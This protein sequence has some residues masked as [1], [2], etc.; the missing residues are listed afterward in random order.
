MGE[1]TPLS[2]IQKLILRDFYSS[3]NQ[4]IAVKKSE[5]KEIWDDFVKNRNIK[6]Y[7]HLAEKVPAFF[8]ELNKALTVNKN[9]QPAVFSECVYAQ[10]LAQKFKLPKFTNLLDAKNKGFHNDTVE[11]VN[12]TGLSV[13]YCYSNADDT[14]L[15]FQAGGAGSVDCALISQIEK[16]L[17]MIEFKE[18]YART[19]EPD[20]P[21]YDEEGFLTSSQKFDEKYPQFKL[22]LG[23]QLDKRLNVFTHL[24]SNEANFSP[25]SIEYAVLKNYSGSKFADVIC[26]EDDSGF[27]VML[28]TEHVSKW[29]ILEGE[30]RPTGRNSYK[31]WSPNKLIKSLRDLGAKFDGEIVT[32]PISQIKST[33]ERG[34]S[35]ISRY[36]INPLFF[37]RSKNIEFHGK[38]ASFNIKSIKQN[39]PSITAKMNFKGLKIEEVKNY[40][41][42]IL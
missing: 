20:L 36:K 21:K 41:L 2:R 26:T 25:E 18:Q 14:K 4:K 27:L 38:S 30:I 12:S 42:G 35:N 6:K 19:S 22:M 7:S 28:P 17:I 15:L 24:G 40:Y 23:E 33:K 32:I 31:V 34:G 8:A 39:N 10:S 29:A 3:S 5:R 9:L 16:N 11:A 37:V 13:R 1:L